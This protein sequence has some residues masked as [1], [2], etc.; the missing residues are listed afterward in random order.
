MT[1]H[2]FDIVIGGA[3]KLGSRIVNHTL[4]AGRSVRVLSRRPPH[5][6]RIQTVAGSITNPDSGARSG[7][8]RVE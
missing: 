4:D 7:E 3:G 5:D 2:T 1:Q 6:D 8:Q